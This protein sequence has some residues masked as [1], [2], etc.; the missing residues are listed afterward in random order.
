MNDNTAG[1]LAGVGTILFFIF[2]M[3]SGLNMEAAFADPHLVFKRMK[4]LKK[5]NSVLTKLLNAQKKALPKF[6]IF[7]VIAL[8]AA[9]IAIT[10]FVFLNKSVDEEEKNK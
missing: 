5:N 3:M 10:G 1:I 4:G 9:T 7:T 2:A 8:V 6:Q